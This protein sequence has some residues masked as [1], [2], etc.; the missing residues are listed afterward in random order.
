APS[1]QMTA[2]IR[3]TLLRPAQVGGDLGAAGREW[4]Q[5]SCPEGLVLP[6]QADQPADS[7]PDKKSDDGEKPQEGE[8]KDKDL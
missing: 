1:V 4:H 3:V 7:A 6:A 2:M 8:F 5:R